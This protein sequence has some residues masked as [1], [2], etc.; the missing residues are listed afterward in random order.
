MKKLII[1]Q[2]I[3]IVI[4]V[5]ATTY[6]FISC[7]NYKS[8]ISVLNK[9]IEQINNDYLLYKSANKELENKI[10]QLEAEKPK[11]PIEIREQK[12]ISKDYSTAGMNNCV[13]LATNEWYQEIDK[14]ISLLKSN[15]TIE[16]YK[17]LADSQKKWQQ[18]EQSQRTFLDATIG[19][20]AGSIYTNILA[21]I[22]NEIVKRRAEDLFEIYD[23]YTD[24]SISTFFN[25]K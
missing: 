8:R 9:Q 14:N 7:L 1:F 2:I 24:Y 4:L 19:T 18:Y 5:V 17:L 22:K 15:V 12:C 23:Y 3:V 25:N 21:G 6:S 10:N 11:N 20:K 16:Q 13:Y